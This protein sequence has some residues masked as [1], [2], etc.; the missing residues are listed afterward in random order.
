MGTRKT[1]FLPSPYFIFSPCVSCFVGFFSLGFLFVCFLL[2][3]EQL[4]KASD[5][6]K[7]FLQ[8]ANCIQREGIPQFCSTV[9]HAASV[10]PPNKRSSKAF[11]EGERSESCTA[12]T[13]K[14]FLY[15]TMLPAMITNINH[16][17]KTLYY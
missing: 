4:F 10:L 15:L 13:M 14:T 2:F 16:Q 17:W 1:F 11:E 7:L 5:A 3:K 6:K 8:K 12:R 9:P